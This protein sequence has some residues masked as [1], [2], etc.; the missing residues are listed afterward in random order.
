MTKT[1]VQQELEETITEAVSTLGSA[2]GWSKSEAI[3]QEDLDF[4]GNTDLVVY[5]TAP[6]WDGYEAADLDSV[7]EDYEAFSD[8]FTKEALTTFLSSG[9]LC[10]VVAG[11]DEDQG[12]LRMA[13][14][15]REAATAGISS[16]NFADKDHLTKLL[17]VATTNRLKKAAG[18]NDLKAIQHKISLVSLPESKLTEAQAN[19]AKTRITGLLGEVL[20]ATL[21]FVSGKEVES[22]ELG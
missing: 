3:D 20:L 6:D 21:S 5:K 4:W 13:V 11:S 2:K 14:I 12:E 15:D 7:K 19:R 16:I 1:Q 8:I 18:N 22:L 17:E 9:E 10:V